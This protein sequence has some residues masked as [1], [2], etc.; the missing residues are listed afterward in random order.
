MIRTLS[1]PRGR[2]HE[3][4]DAPVIA[5][6]LTESANNRRYFIGS[7]DPWQGIERKRDDFFQKYQSRNWYLRIIENENQKNIG[8]RP[9]PSALFDSKRAII[10]HGMVEAYEGWNIRKKV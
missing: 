5:P 3:R 9:N 7:R 1:Q 8:V 4:S 10:I 6:R 2:S